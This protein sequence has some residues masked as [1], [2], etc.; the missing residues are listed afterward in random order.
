MDF[1]QNAYAVRVCDTFNMI[2]CN[3]KHN[4]YA[5]DRG[6]H[7]L[8]SGNYYVGNLCD[9]DRPG[10][11]TGGLHSLDWIYASDTDLKLVTGVTVANYPYTETSPDPMQ[12]MN[13]R[14]SAELE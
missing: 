13:Y 5:I 12:V 14:E 1:L 3:F 10:F 8:L 9:L 4:V 2:N 11:D 6:V 7:F